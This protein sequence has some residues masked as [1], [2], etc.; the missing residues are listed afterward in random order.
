MTLRTIF[1]ITIS[2]ALLFL[3]LFMTAVI[4]FPVKEILSEMIISWSLDQTVILFFKW[5]I[6]IH[7]AAIIIGFSL[8]LQLPSGKGFGSAISG[9]LIVFIS[10]AVGFFILQET[11]LPSSYQRQQ[12]REYQTVRA[13]DLQKLYQEDPNGPNA[14]R[15]VEEYLLINPQSVE[16]VT[17]R[18]NLYK[19]R[20]QEPQPIQEPGQ[21][22]IPFELSAAGYLQRA[23]EFYRNDDL[24][25]ALWYA[26]L[27]SGLNPRLGEP[28]FLI[29]QILSEMREADSSEDA[30][31]KRLFS[32]KKQR[33]I[34]LLASNINSV[35]GQSQ[36][37]EAYTMLKELS[38]ESQ[39]EPDPDVQRYLGIAEQSIRGL[40]YSEE[41]FREYENVSGF[42]K[43]AFF[44]ENEI[45]GK[46]II[47][48]DRFIDDL[49]TRFAYDVSIIG[50][51]DT[52]RL[53]Y[54]IQADAAEVVHGVLLLR[55][56]S[57]GTNR[58]VRLPRLTQGTV[59][60][61]LLLYT[62]P[63]E[64]EAY[65]L[66]GYSLAEDFLQSQSLV[67]LSNVI[68]GYEEAR[69][70]TTPLY[71]Q[72]LLRLNFP[73][74]MMLLSFGAIGVGWAFRPEKKG[75]RFSTVIWILALPFA[76]TIFTDLLQFALRILFLTFLQMSGIII[77]MIIIVI[78]NGAALT[79]ILLFLA[80][81]RKAELE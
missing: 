76:L 57:F 47:L 81:Q 5:L 7:T 16:M 49:Y 37:L 73:F 21:E 80:M 14:L 69:L 78:L 62:I 52:G 40:R 55:G 4:N 2:Y 12:V 65:K 53:R 70:P 19:S 17:N 50:L 35:E 75:L 20:G 27:S 25:S 15:Y 18:E 63:L 32:E 72:V 44:Q 38:V 13:R 36:I 9:S 59:P 33:A 74:L 3:V 11:L 66:S 43:I 31:Q 42:Q 79:G 24:D 46:Q 23:R 77:S 1:T 71:I 54:F 6:P 30:L 29:A 56:R 58:D 68:G 51:T 28:K 67:Y 8:F 41:K 26:E 10:V 45:N 48:F 22:E 61:S 60:S 64:V 39:S 34:S